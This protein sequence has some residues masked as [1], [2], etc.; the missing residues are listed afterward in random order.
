MRTDPLAAELSFPSE[1]I[2][3]RQATATEH[4]DMNPN[5]K[6]TAL[7]LR[8]RREAIVREHIEAD[9]LTCEKV[10]FDMAT[11]MRQLQG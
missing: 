2:C 3:S 9:R 10:Y 6:P 1:G 11:L 4:G 7:D 8:Q 5:T